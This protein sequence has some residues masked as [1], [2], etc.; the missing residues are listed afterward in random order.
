M[1]TV[2]GL[3]NQSL[4]RILSAPDLERVVPRLQPEILH[5]IVLEHGLADCAEVI[6]FA[7]PAQLTQVFDLDLW[8]GEPGGDEEFDADRFGLWLEVM[9]SAGAG[10]AAAKVAEMPAA[11]IIA[12]LVQHTR[13]YDPA[14]VAPYETTDGVRVEIS[15]DDGVTCVVG[16]YHVVA[17][18]DVSWDAIVELLTALAT[19]HHTAFHR[20]MRGVLDLSDH[21]REPD[22][23]DD[24]ADGREQMMFDLAVDRAQRRDAQ[25]YVTPAEARAFLK[26]CRLD[27]APPAAQ[28]AG[29]SSTA[30][31][32]LA[33]VMMAG[34]SIQRRAFTAREAADA[35]VAV[36]KLGVE[37]WQN[38][39]TDGAGDHTVIAAFQEGW[40]TLQ[41]Q[42]IMPSTL[43][44]IEALT[45]LRCEDPDTQSELDTLRGTLA[46]QAEAGEPWRV[47]EALDTITILDL[48]ASAVLA[49]LIAEFP[50]MPAGLTASL[51]SRVRRFDAHAFEFISAGSQIATIQRY[52]QSLPEALSGRQ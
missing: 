8:R 43:A 48:P 40:R 27:A 29:D 46:K 3:P 22:G 36:C 16:G 18:S 10:L 15:T 2:A 50:V 35:V 21:A 44:L 37:Q 24:L 11:L 51:D 7:T 30:I 13:V 17:L 49:G 32:F 20:I 52:L 1:D 19:A 31:T 38:K 6:A 12:G 39:L 25:G 9:L 26:V 28:P 47:G 14:S 23:L 33:N 5:Q 41:G 45:D 34:C 42:V 4:A